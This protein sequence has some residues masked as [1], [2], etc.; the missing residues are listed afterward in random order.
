MKKETIKK[1]LKF[2]RKWW[3]IFAV[4]FFFVY[5]MF[6]DPNNIMVRMDYQNE[7]DSLKTILDN[8]KNQIKSDSIQIEELKNSKEAVEKYAREKYGYKH[9]D[10]DVFII[11]A[12]I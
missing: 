5:L 7:L 9:P 12:G 6:F 2:S 8:Y 11:D 3:L 10:E 4:L 1:I